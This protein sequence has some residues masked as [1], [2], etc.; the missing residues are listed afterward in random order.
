MNMILIHSGAKGQKWGKRN[1][2]N[3]DGTLT[4]EGKK[5]YDYYDN[6]T[7]RVYSSAKK[8]QSKEKTYRKTAAYGVKA[9]D[10]SRYSISE[11]EA[12]SKRAEAERR[13][14]ELY[15]AY[16]ENTVKQIANKAYT[17]LKIT[18]GTIGSI[19]GILKGI[20]TIRKFAKGKDI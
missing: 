9:E 15:G 4:E 10:L 12:L 19:A 13:Y 7:D 5:R 20:S 18:G 2:R 3:Y 17:A 6:K 16:K 8:K 14:R 11:L 1:Y